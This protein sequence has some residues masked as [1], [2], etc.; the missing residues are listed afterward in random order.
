M[1]GFGWTGI[2]ALDL[3]LA[4]LGAI[5]IALAVHTT[6]CCLLAP[7][8]RGRKVPPIL[9]R[10]LRAP[11][12]W[13]LVL[14]AVRAVWQE[15]PEDIA[16]RSELLHA[17]TLALIVSLTWLA[18]R[19][20]EALVEIVV[21]LNPSEIENNLHARRIRTQ[22]NVLGRTLQVFV[23]VFGTAMALVTFP[24]VR[25]FGSA[26]MASAGVA[27]LVVGLAAR[28]VLSNIVAGLQLAFTQPIRI[29]D[30]LIVKGE[31]GRV[32]EIGGAFV[33][34]KIWDER[35][36]VIPLQWFIENPFENWT[37]SGSNIVG[38]LFLWTD[39]RM[40][41]APLR[42]EFMRQC[43]A[44]K[45]WDGRLAALQVTDANE[46]AMQIRAVVSSHDAGKNWDLRCRLREGLVDYLQREHP[47]SLPRV[48]ASAEI[49]APA[50]WPQIAT[51]R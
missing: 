6:I 15:A 23:G 12:R 50:R 41:V 42:E 37:R 27:G 30:V 3:I 43:R 8:Y 22:A 44:A 11:S 18:I 39:Y 25:D 31:W 38:S 45:E 47:D 7:L 13:V 34:V 10:Q 36:L 29:D 24:G 17:T 9:L 40:P 51:G 26:L 2:A 1:E 49:Q 4:L 21:L 35:R 14:L 48:R 46:R 20:L 28:P 5:A 16:H 32:E 33:V 19:A